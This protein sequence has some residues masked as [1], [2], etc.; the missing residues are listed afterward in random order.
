MQ[1]ACGCTYVQ[2]GKVAASLAHA[3]ASPPHSR[4]A[5]A[6]H[7][8]TEPTVAN[9]EEAIRTGPYGRC[10]WESDNDVLDNQVQ[11]CA[12][13]RSSSCT[14]THSLP[15]ML[16][17]PQMVNIQF[18]NGTTSNLTTVAYTKVNACAST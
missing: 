6:L 3:R 10:V 15:A 4:R 9:I 18:A 5:M 12:F 11:G 2:Q 14:L 7:L 17:A 8:T 1:R 13:F 16:H